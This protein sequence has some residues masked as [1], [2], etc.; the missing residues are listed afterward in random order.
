MYV[1]CYYPGMLS[2]SL[3]VN[4][5]LPNANLSSYMDW[6]PKKEKS[7]LLKMA[8]LRCIRKGNNRIGIWSQKLQII[9][10]LKFIFSR[11]NILLWGVQILLLRL[12]ELGPTRNIKLPPPQAVWE[13]QQ[14]LF[15]VTCQPLGI[16]VLHYVCP[17]KMKYLL[18]EDIAGMVDVHQQPE[19]QFPC[20]NRLSTKFGYHLSF[21]STVH[22]ALFFV[23]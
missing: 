19:L 4:E 17:A 16:G 9:V 11:R 10:A 5:Q 12:I 3:I 22:K 6:L 13:I 21:L 14:L 1:A 8:K 23:E 18:N 20:S 2:V 7:L 15:V